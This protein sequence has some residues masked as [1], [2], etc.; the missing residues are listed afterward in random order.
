[1][2]TQACLD[3]IAAMPPPFNQPCPNICSDKNFIDGTHCSAMGFPPDTPFMVQ[4]NCNGKPCWCYCCCSC[5]TRDTP[6][7]QSPG[8]YVLVQDVHAGD[9]LLVCGADLQW[10]PGTVKTSS[11]DV[12]PSSYQG[13]Y[14]LMY[15]FSDEDEPRFIF[16]TPDHLFMMAADRTLK[17]IQYLA[18]N[19]KILRSDGNSASVVFV[20]RGTYNTSLHT[21]TMDGEFDGV[22]LDGHLLNANGLVTTDYVVQAY[23]ASQNID[24]RLL[25]KPADGNDLPEVGEPEYLRRYSNPELQSFLKDRSRWPRGFVPIEEPLINVPKDALGFV[26]DGYAEQI[27]ANGKFSPSS[28]LTPQVNVY[29]VLGY[30]RALNPG[31]IYLLDWNNSLPNAYGWRSAGQTFVLITGGFARLEGLYTEGLSLILSSVQARLNGAPCAADADYVAITRIMRDIWPGQMVPTIFP[32]AIDQVRMALE[33]VK[34]PVVGNNCESPTTDCRVETFVR[35]ISFMGIPDCAKPIVEEF[36]LV[37]AVAAASLTKVVVTFSEAAE[38]ATG[39][40]SENYVFAPEVTVTEAAVG[41][42]NPALVTL[43]VS[44]LE[45]GG[46]YLLTVK[47]VL[48]ANGTPLDPAHDSIKVTMPK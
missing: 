38:V 28:N 8:Q 24:E 29:K 37:R 41:K 45:K 7:E 5:F 40:T 42:K 34:E 18:P 13:M 11:G 2:P 9:E 46:S 19:D 27:Q 1:M 12:S 44:G 31:V 3:K 14:L 26:I 17:A 15:R 6:L 32:A 25:F 36:D 21:I 4:D 39:E 20:A 43:T 47:N 22:H 10:T 16:V 35:G 30:L 48:S 23:Y 33:L